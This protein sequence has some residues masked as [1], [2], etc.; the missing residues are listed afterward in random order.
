MF[1]AEYFEW[2]FNKHNVSVSIT[3][4]QRMQG[5][6]TY[7]QLNGNQRIPESVSSEVWCLPHEFGHASFGAIQEMHSDFFSELRIISD[8]I[9]QKYSAISSEYL[10]TYGTTSQNRLD[11]TLAELFDT[12][13]CSE[14][15]R[16]LLKQGMPEVYEFAAKYL[17]PPL[18]G[19]D[20]PEGGG[21]SSSS[22]SIK[23]FV[24]NNG[25][26]NTIFIADNKGYFNL[27]YCIG[28]SETCNISSNRTSLNKINISSKVSGYK[29]DNVNLNFIT[30]SS[31]LHI[32]GS[33]GTGMT[34]VRKVQFSK[35]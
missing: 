35:K 34:L 6:V 25:S 24:K 30:S 11:E 14:E 5:G 8:I 13:Y 32:Y 1:P 3:G 20:V 29:I 7:L 19:N 23:L 31:P 15:A 9:A 4:N 33:D 2:V 28:S 12:W 27:S 10:N 26:T 22:S 18:D 17:L 21:T 16:N